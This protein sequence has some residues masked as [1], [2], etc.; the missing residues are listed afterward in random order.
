MNGKPKELDVSIRS[1]GSRACQNNRFFHL[2]NCSLTSPGV[3]E[4]DDLNALIDRSAPRLSSA[5]SDKVEWAAW[6]SSGLRSVNLHPLLSHSATSLP[7]T[8]C[9]VRCGTPF[10]ISHS[11]RVVASKNP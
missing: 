2:S 7:T 1:R 9:A 4:P 5:P 11:I 10:L 3:V 8:S 6:R